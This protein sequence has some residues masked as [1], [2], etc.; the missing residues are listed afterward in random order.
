MKILQ[1]NNVYDFGSTGKITRDIHHGLME[2]GFDSCVYYGRRYKTKDKNVHKVCSELYGKAQNGLSRFTGIKYGGC[3]FSTNS[4]IKAIRKEKPDIVHL[5]CL[6][7]YF[8][9]VYRLL[10]FLK[11]NRIPTVLTVH[12]EFMYTG[13]CS[14]ALE[15][16]E[17]RNPAGCGSIKCP[18]YQK[19]IKSFAGDKSAKMWKLMADCFDGFDKLKVISVSPW[20]LERARQ[21][22]ILKNK[23]HSVI[24]NGI[25]TSVFKKR[26]QSET[27]SL[28]HEL[29]ISY[30]K[31]I[32]I[33]VTPLFNDNPNNI[34]GGL[35]LIKTALELPETVFLIVGSY[36][37]NVKVPENVILLGQIN[38]RAKLAGLY[39]LADV[40]VL[41]SKRETFSMICAESLCCGTPVVGFKA[42]APEVI[43]IPEF[44]AFCEFGDTKKLA[45]LIAGRIYGGKDATAISYKAVKTYS[46]ERMIDEYINVYLTLAEENR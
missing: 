44:S 35:W 32:A 34:K 15:C 5:Q 1:I 42:G 10:T 20:L 26:P 45:E 17:W 38:N 37:K 36:D 2:R 19:G 21:S 46:T 7:G 9:N 29:G 8:V 25:D 14:H 39:S 28:R 40:T 23:D 6:N 16:D 33:H 27:D 13:G 22:T 30:T 24:L 18:R 11:E 12:A 43:S 4:I 31:K 41:T 3:Y